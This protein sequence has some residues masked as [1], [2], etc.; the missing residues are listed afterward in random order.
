LNK[1]TEWMKIIEKVA[2]EGDEKCQIILTK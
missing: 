2:K 1:I